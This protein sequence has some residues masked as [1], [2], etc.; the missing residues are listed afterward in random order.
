MWTFFDI[1]FMLFVVALHIQC[2]EILENEGS[3]VKKELDKCER[4][5]VKKLY[6]N[7]STIHS[8]RY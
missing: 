4:M 1:F 3:R 5:A 7:P 8:Y 2:D 6:I